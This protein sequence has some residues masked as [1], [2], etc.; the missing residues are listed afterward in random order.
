MD[1]QIATS[2]SSNSSTEMTRNSVSMVFPNRAYFYSSCQLQNFSTPDTIIF[3]VSKNPS[4]SKFYQKMIQSC[5]YFFIKNPIIIVPELW[6]YQ[7][8]G[9]Y[10]EG[11][12]PSE[13]FP[14]G[15]LVY[16]NELTSKIWITDSLDVWG[17]TPIWPVVTSFM[18]KIYQCDA[19][20]IFINEQMFSF[21]D[22]MHIASKCEVLCLLSVVIMNNDEI[23]LETEE[24]QIYF[25]TAVSLEAIFKALPNVKEFTYKLPENSL[26]IITT[27]TAKELLKIPHFLSLDKFQISQIPEIFDIK[28]FFGYIKEN[29]K[30]NIQ[31]EFPYQISDAYNIQLQAIVDEILEM[32]LNFYNDYKVPWIS[33][34]GMTRSSYNTMCTLYRQN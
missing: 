28:S 19:T 21:N 25:E 5:K 17:N 30:T 23:V 8:T 12:R 1:S 33:F 29:K 6:F 24:D 13:D 3:Y 7:R 18:P 27:K 15:R 9:W 31:L 32:E 26:N 20:S 2:N 4:T 14:N 11:S 34:S 22:L 16:L 10:T